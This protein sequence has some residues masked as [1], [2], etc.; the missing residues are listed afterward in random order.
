MRGAAD[1]EAQVEVLVEVARPVHSEAHQ[2]AVHVVGLHSLVPEVETGGPP[3]IVRS[4]LRHD[5]HH[6]AGRLHF[7]AVG[8]DLDL[9]LLEGVHVEVEL[10]TAVRLVVG[11]VRPVQ[12]VDVLS[13][14]HPVA[15]ER[16]LV[17]GL[18]AP[19]V[20]AV[21]GYS[22][23][24]GDHRPGIPG[25]RD[26]LHHFLGEVEGHVRR[27]G[28]D[29]RRLAGHR[30]RLLD[31][32][33]GELRVQGER[34]VRRDPDS[35]KHLR[36]EAAER[37]GD[38]VHPGRNVP[39]AKGA[40]SSGHRGTGTTEDVGPGDR[41]RDPG[42]N[43]GRG[44][45]HPALQGS[46]LFLGQNRRGKENK[47]D[48]QEQTPHGEPPHISVPKPR[49]RW[50]RCCRSGPTHAAATL[51]WA[52]GVAGNAWMMGPINPTPSVG[53]IRSEGWASNGQT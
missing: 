11:D 46:R 50:P 18:G 45:R 27:L 35:F 34:G 3:E 29:H 30:D 2:V 25:V 33:D 24:L 6:H 9:H 7:G 19:D 17:S 38:L 48:T 23:N 22:G 26:V 44:V 41:H 14:E 20:D 28:L 4:G 1:F 16:E 49:A 36:A 12:H 10:R 31:A 13:G 15:P 51:G 32:R 40:V 53:Y 47:A 21:R 39:E 5:V 43:A 42:E 8:A 52:G 37:E